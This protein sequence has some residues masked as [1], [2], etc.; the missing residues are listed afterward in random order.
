[1][2]FVKIIFAV[3]IILVIVA[4]AG[5][6]WIYSSLNSPHEHD[7]TTQFI[8]IEKGSTPAEIIGKLYAE[9]ILAD[10]VPIRTYLRF[11]GDASKIQAGEYQFPSPITPLQVLKAL[12]SGEDR[13]G[14]TYH[15][16]R[17]YAI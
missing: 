11:F 14:E 3:I 4:A 9:G 10:R 7:K 12:E 8:K 2:K 16:R 17:L 5:S 1:M 15:S 13:I 6:W